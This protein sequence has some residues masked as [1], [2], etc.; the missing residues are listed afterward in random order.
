MDVNCSSEHPQEWDAS[1]DRSLD[2]TFNA[3]FDFAEEV[4]PSGCSDGDNQA[5][6]GSESRE[7]ATVERSS[8]LNFSAE[9]EEASDED[10]EAS[11]SDMND[12]IDPAASCAQAE[13]EHL[14]VCALCSRLLESLTPLRD[15]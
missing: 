12:D 5:C 1:I 7:A 9:L 6:N 4:S 14:R 8:A 15:A 3:S 2:G 10:A 13:A 11:A